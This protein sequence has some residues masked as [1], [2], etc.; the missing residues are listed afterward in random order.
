MRL[1]SLVH[2]LVLC[3]PG[4]GALDLTHTA[5][6]QAEMTAQ[7]PADLQAF[8]SY[9]VT[10]PDYARTSHSFGLTAGAHYDR[11]FGS[12]FIPGL[13]LR[14][15]SNSGSVITEHAYLFGPRVHTELRRRY[16]PYADFLVGA[17]SLK[18]LEDGTMVPDGGFVYDVGLGMDI[19]LVHNVMFKEDF[20][21]QSWN[22]GPNSYTNPNGGDFKISPMV[23]TFGVSYRIPFRQW[24]DQAHVSR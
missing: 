14:A 6:A 8:V 4:A 17:G 22:L 1:R 10:L 18:H 7:R 11:S 3:L 16:H 15:S 24:T 13:E 5:Q 23:L 20:Q 12:R 9:G 19:D 21:L 2:L